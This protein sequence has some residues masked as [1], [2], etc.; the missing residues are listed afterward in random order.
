[1]GP[2]SGLIFRL[3]FPGAL[4]GWLL[5]LLATFAIFPPGMATGQA[6]SAEKINSALTDAT[7]FEA[8]VGYRPWRQYFGADG[9]TT[10]FGKDGPSSQGHWEVRGNQYCS[11][12]PPSQEWACYDVELGKDEKGRAV[13]TWISANGE[14][15][16]ATMVSGNHVAQ[17]S[18][19]E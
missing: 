18:L 14:R 2:V 19:P 12:W 7:G 8:G 6:A 17:R 11:L 3:A 15:T 13:V 9:K 1:M 16:A 10:Y 5:P 4:R